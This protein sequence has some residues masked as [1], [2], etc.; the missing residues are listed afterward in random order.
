MGI[1][2]FNKVYS[3]LI[4]N[5]RYDM[6]TSKLL[7]RSDLMRLGCLTFTKHLEINNL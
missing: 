6:Y 4:S 5:I 2:L 1:Y 3:K 7:K